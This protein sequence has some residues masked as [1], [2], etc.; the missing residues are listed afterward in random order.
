MLI[1]VLTELL[2]DIKTSGLDLVMIYWRSAVLR[3]FLSK[4]VDRHTCSLLYI[5]CK[6]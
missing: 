6:P 2:N 4:D 1:R 5:N 3:N